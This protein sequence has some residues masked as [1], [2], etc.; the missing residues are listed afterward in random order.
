MLKRAIPTMAL[1]LFAIGCTHKTPVATKAP[2]KAPEPMSRPAPSAPA[3]V[4]TRQEPTRPVERTVTRETPTKEELVQID[5]LLARIQDAY[6]DYDKHSLRSDAEQALK[7]DAQTLSEIIRRYP[8]F[9]LVVEG[10]CD[11]RGSDEYNLALGNARAEKSKEYLV[12]LGLPGAQL[13]T[14]SYGKQKPVCDSDS[15]DCWQ[16]NRRAHLARA[17]T[18]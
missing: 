15:E 9:K 11:D 14:I 6:F 17:D 12:S 2:E 8:K 13:N 10:H 5:Q 18:N 1:V 16:K 3:R 4:A 7:A